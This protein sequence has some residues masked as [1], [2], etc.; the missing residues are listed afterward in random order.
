MKHR[1]KDEG[2]KLAADFEASGLTEREFAEQR[3]IT[4]CSLQYWKRRVRQLDGAAGKGCRNRFVEIAVS[5]GGAAAMRV[6]TGKLEIFFPTLPPSGWLHEFV[7]SL[8]NGK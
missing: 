7:A 3:G 1:T 6:S 2:R 8:S 4:L 5:P